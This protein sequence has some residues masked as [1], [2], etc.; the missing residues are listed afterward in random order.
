MI[1]TCSRCKVEASSRCPITTTKTLSKCSLPLRDRQETVLLSW[2]RSWITRIRATNSS[3]SYSIIP[4]AKTKRFRA[5]KSLSHQ[6]LT[7]SKKSSHPKLLQTPVQETKS[8]RIISHSNLHHNFIFR[9]R[10]LWNAQLWLSPRKNSTDSSSFKEQ[11]RTRGRYR[12]NLRNRRSSSWN[13]E[14][15]HVKMSWGYCSKSSMTNLEKWAHW[16]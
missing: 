10:F 6:Q 2:R 16:R 1:M 13:S 3:Q 8:L 9:V 4:S 11:R 15:K 14:K 7:R 5:T 12:K